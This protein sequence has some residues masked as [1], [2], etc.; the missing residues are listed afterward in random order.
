MEGVLANSSRPRRRP[1]DA[2]GE[3]AAMVGGKELHGVATVR[4]IESTEREGN[5]AKLTA[6]SIGDERGSGTAVRA[7]SRTAE[8]GARGGGCSGFLGAWRS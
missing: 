6:T 2:A 5:K 1:E 8:L 7:V 4:Q 3:V